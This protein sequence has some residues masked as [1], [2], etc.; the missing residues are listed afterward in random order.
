MFA[1]RKANRSLKLEKPKRILNRMKQIHG[2]PYSVL[3]LLTHECSEEELV[4][5]MGWFGCERQDLYDK[6]TQE[7]EIGKA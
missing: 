2:D 1:G 4:I 5:L 3:G 7:L 6:V